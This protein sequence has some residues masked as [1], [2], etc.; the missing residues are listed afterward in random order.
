MTSGGDVESVVS[1]L[2]QSSTHD[3][4]SGRGAAASPPDLSSAEP[5]GE[6]GDADARPGD[7]TLPAGQP[8][9]F[10]VP[11]IPTPAGSHRA[12]VVNGR[13]VVTHDSKKT[14]PWRQDVV[15]AA[16]EALN[17]QPPLLGPVEVAVEFVMPRPKSHWRTG[18]NAHLLREAAPTWPAGKPDL[19]KLLRNLFDALTAAGVFR[20][21]AQVVSVDATKTY[22]DFWPKPCTHVQVAAL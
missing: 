17:G 18:R 1:R 8:L 3:A 16:V 12:F 13:A 7:S 6:A 2:P 20:D 10:T 22:V 14:K 5:V 11:G 9:S 19:D 21:D 4:P 15:S